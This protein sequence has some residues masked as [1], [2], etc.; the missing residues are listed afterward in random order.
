[1]R[2]CGVRYGIAMTR[3]MPLLLAVLLAACSMDSVAGRILPDDVRAEAEQLTTEI[4]AGEFETIRAAFPDQ[5]G[6]ELDAF[7]GA[8]AEGVEGKSELARE[9]VG[10]SA[11]VSADLE[12]ASQTYSIV[13]EVEIEDT[14]VVISQVWVRSGNAGL[15]LLNVDIVDTDVSTAAQLRQAG[16][17]ARIVGGGLLVV[18]GLLVLLL[19]RRRRRARAA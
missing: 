12:G 10:V 2:L 6:P 15:S 18:G 11:S 1:M 14:F 17:V 5:A 13:H 8:V 7:L 4:M 3:L 19:V 9:I 16:R